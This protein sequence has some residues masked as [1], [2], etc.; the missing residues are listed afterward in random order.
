MNN[1]YYSLQR[2]TTSQLDKIAIGAIW[3]TLHIDID[4]GIDYIGY[5]IDYI[6]YG[7]IKKQGDGCLNNGSEKISGDCMSQGLNMTNWHG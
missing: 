1:V 2:L 6:G 3:T 5:R 4:Y 7:G